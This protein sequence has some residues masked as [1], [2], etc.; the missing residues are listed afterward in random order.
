MFKISEFE[1]S[2]IIKEVNFN[3]YRSAL[4]MRREL[5]HCLRGYYLTPEQWYLLA[6]FTTSGRWYSQKEICIQFA[7]DAPTISRMLKRMEKNGWIIRSA[8]KEDKRVTL[9]KTTEKGMNFQEIIM[10]EIQNHFASL[11]KELSPE[12]LKTLVELLV[13]YRSSLKEDVRLHLT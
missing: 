9:F 12:K 6:A 2:L 7:L 3:I 10:S 1:S 13:D 8:D 5:I 4:L 11:F